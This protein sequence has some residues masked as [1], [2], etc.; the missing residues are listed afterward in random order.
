M[1]KLALERGYTVI[2]IDLNPIYQIRH[3]NFSFICAD[4]LKVEA[5]V[6]FDW[7]LNIST[8]EH[9]G[10]CRYGVEHYD[11][12]ADLRGMQKLR[13]WLRG[14]ML[15][16]VPV[17]VD[18]IHQPLHRVYGEQRLPKLLDG[19]VI[20]R[21]EYFAK[22]YSDDYVRVGKEYALSDHS[23]RYGDDANTNYYAL[24]LFIVRRK[25]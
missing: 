4:F 11:E 19:Y 16:T 3:P 21:E 24:G 25:E 1:S 22:P 15:L 17:G 20:E 9:F 5:R 2:A 18:E 10:L 13:D 7:I 8:I 12:D 6:E 23:E 14:K